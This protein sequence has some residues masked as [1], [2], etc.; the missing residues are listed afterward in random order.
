MVDTEIS[1]NDLKTENQEN[2]SGSFEVVKQAGDIVISSIILIILS[3][4]L[5]LLAIL[6]KA[7][8]KGP[9]IYSQDRIGKDGKPF[10]IYKFRSM[11]YNSENGEPLLS[12]TSEE[13]ITRIGKFL[14]KY[15]IDEIPNFLNVLKGEM[16]LVGPR[17]ERQYFIDQI[18]K[19]APEYKKL[20]KVKPGIT[21][22]GQVRYGYASNVDEMIE[23]LEYD[24]YYLKNRSFW[25]DLKIIIITVG[26][27]LKGKGI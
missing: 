17:P 19:I 24:L 4:I 14:R 9:V 7:S 18:I 2:I 15:R 6:I 20:H 1:T 16:S 11:V 12:K 27:I 3:P 10:V 21:S 8:G 26:I 5:I 13:R 22:W 23:R 25:F